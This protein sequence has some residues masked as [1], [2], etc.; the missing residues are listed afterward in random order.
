M[1]VSPGQSRDFF[2]RRFNTVF[3]FYQEQESKQCSPNSRPDNQRKAY[4]NKMNLFLCINVLT[5]NKFE[6][7]I[8]NQ[9]IHKK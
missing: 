9:G 7:E 5:K 1:A 8:R 2:W 3:W 6:I 4:I